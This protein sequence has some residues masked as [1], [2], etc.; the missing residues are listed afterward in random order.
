MQTDF[1]T[2]ITVSNGQWGVNRRVNGQ[3]GWYTDAQVGL[4]IPKIK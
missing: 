2:C 4:V 1:L 3:E